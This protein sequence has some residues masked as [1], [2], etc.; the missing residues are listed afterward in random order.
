MRFEYRHKLFDIVGVS[1]NDHIYRQI[2]RLQNFYEIDL[3]EYILSLGP[4]LRSNNSKNVAIDVG[5]NIGNHSIYYASFIADYLIAI[6]PN[7]VVLD[8]LRR[9]L[10]K[11]IENYSIWDYA[12]GEKEGVGSIEMPEGMGDNLGAAKISTQNKEGP[13]EITTLDSALSLW[14]K[15]DS[16]PI[17]VSLI[18]IDVEGMEPQVLKGAQKTILEYKPHIFIEAATHEELKRI[19]NFLKP[20]G[21]KKLQG[22]WAATPVYHFS[23]K[24]KI[25]LVIHCF[26]MQFK[27]R[28]TNKINR[29]TRHFTER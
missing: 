4:Y 26:Y 21:Y 18:K 19:V 17:S 13:I 15:N 28:V 6:E 22:H 27:K 16:S 24:P 1:H 5:A 8:T 3:L 20:L 12:V 14:K 9:N 11:N 10:S 25:T 23:F 7:P 2:S 29:L